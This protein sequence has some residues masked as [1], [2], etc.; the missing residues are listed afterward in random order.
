MTPLGEQRI[1]LAG[2]EVGA[3]AYRVTGDLERRLWYDR[4]GNWLRSQL[5]YRGKTITLTRQ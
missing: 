4:D 3:Q 2:G 1:A 5:S